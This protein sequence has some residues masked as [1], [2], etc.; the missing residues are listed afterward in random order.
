MKAVFTWVFALVLVAQGTALAADTPPTPT[1][2]Q[3]LLSVFQVADVPADYVVVVDT[4]S[5]MM[6]QPAIY[7]KVVTA[8]RSF[9]DALGT[10]DTL[11]VITFD[12]VGNLRFA[13]EITAGK[14][15]KQAKTALPVSARGTATDI[16]A[17]INAAL[18]RLERP[19]S[20]E[21]QTL[22]FLTDGE[23]NA[24]SGSPYGNAGNTAW[25][26]LH[27]RAVRVAAGHRL[28]VFGAGL[29]GGSTDIGLL[30]QVFPQTQIV[31]LP[32]NQLADFFREAIDNARIERLRT[33]VTD[34]LDQ[35]RLDVVVKPG[36]LGDP[37]RLTV[38]FRSAY[39]HLGSRVILRGVAVT[40][41]DGK[42][43]ESELVGGPR[44]LTL[45]PGGNSQSVYVDV[46]TP[47][48]PGGGLGKTNHARGFV[49]QVDAE[50]R[51]EPADVIG[52][53]LGIS[54]K[55]RLNQ[56]EPATATA[57]TG[58][59]WSTVLGGLLLLLLLLLLLSWIWRRFLRTPPLPGGVRLEDGK[60]IPFKGNR[61]KIPGHDVI[62]NTNGA[63]VRFFTRRGKFRKR[64]PRVY[65]SNE[66]GQSFVNK[67][68]VSTPLSGAQQVLPTDI[69]IVGRARIVVE[70]KG[71]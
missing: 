36:E 55:G 27:Q 61:T 9:V 50:I 62:P 34:E 71:R 59:S 25:K 63:S 1:S 51:V 10:G 57:E 5:S 15:R 49:T 32:T 29:G 64:V 11:S 68:G 52:Q 47:A 35:G 54:T 14:Q 26:Q 31:S 39:P 16:G 66:Q 56:S 23:L 13:D 44:T 43:L 60:F 22:I 41:A 12:T 48:P 4:S 45:G 21:V 20:N 3:D 33:P 40:D 17:G 19:G 69:V 28:S 53:N 65:V 42:E 7:P 58:L 38:T 46:R 24:P 18:G 37:T 30:R 8:Y 67:L 6:D 2:V 70:P